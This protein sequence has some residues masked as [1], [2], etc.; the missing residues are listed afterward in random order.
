LSC[1]PPLAAIPRNQ[2]GSAFVS[3]PGM[4]SN[5][6][7]RPQQESSQDVADFPRRWA[8]ARKGLKIEFILAVALLL[9]GESIVGHPRLESITTSWLLPTELHKLSRRP[10]YPEPFSQ[11]TR[12]CVALAKITRLA[13][14]SWGPVLG[15]GIRA[16][17]FSAIHSD[18]FVNRVIGREGGF[19]T[20]KHLPRNGVI[21]LLLG[22]R[23]HRTR[24]QSPTAPYV[25]E[26]EEENA[27]S[28]SGEKE[29]PSNRRHSQR[30]P[31]QP[32]RK[33]RYEIVP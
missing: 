11:G 18:A 31:Q 27:S 3:R 22:F 2:L 12:A 30:T 29:E 32:E 33:T 19:I 8:W 13:W 25:A 5:L 7:H 21:W 15:E 24:A 17:D 9:G 14:K 26:E 20:L 16:A 28:R 23:G 4:F 1:R 6:L 10:P